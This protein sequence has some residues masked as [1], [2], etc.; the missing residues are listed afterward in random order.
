M[1][2]HIINSKNKLGGNAVEFS[3]KNIY[4]E[5]YNIAVMQEF[6]NANPELISR[7]VR[8][9]VLAV[10]FIERNPEES[11][12]IISKTIGMGESQ[13]AKLWDIYN[14]EISLKQSFVLTLEDQA[15]WAIKN[16]L[17]NKTEVRNY[18]DYIYIDALESVKPEAVT[19]IR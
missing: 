12:S 15:R 13:L 5:T 1:N 11:I 18:L 8:A 4:T 19:I 16:K 10:D 7:I 3:G 9:L 14:F 2:P 6:V 17:T